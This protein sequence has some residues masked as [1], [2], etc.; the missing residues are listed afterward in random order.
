[1]TA[2]PSRPFPLLRLPLELREHVFAFYFNPFDRLVSHYDF[3]PP[4]PAISDGS[5]DR[6]EDT[7]GGGKYSFDFRL[8]RVNKQICGEARGVWKRVAGTFVMVDTPWPTAVHH[9]ST[10]G[11]V[12]IVASGPRASLFRDHTFHVEITAPRYDAHPDHSLVLL[13]E[14]VPLFAKTWY[15]SALSYPVLNTELHVSFKVRPVDGWLDCSYNDGEEKEVGIELQRKMVAPFEKVKG[16]R[17]T[18]FSG[19][20]EKVKEDVLKGMAIPHPSAQE[21]IESCA[22]L[23]AE[24]DTALASASKEPEKGQQAL[25][26]YRRAFH[27]IHVIIENRTRRVLAEGYFHET[28]PSGPFAGQ[29]GTTV[30]ILLR[31]RLVSRHVLA[32]LR[33]KKYGDAAFWGMRSIRI[34]R[35]AMSSEFEDLQTDFPGMSDVGPLCCRT[36]MAFQIMEDDEEVWKEE[37]KGYLEDEAGHS[38]ELWHLAKKYMRGLGREEERK[39]VRLEAKEFGVDIPAGVF[40]EWGKQVASEADSLGYLDLGEEEGGGSS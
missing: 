18:H 5:E 11:F 4:D 37:L 34:M 23:M 9:I 30:R 22:S 16:L 35:E 29:S 1:M 12:P 13:L 27:A 31:I 10:E 7:P 14:D 32:Y 15:Y 39:L 2:T 21:C 40:A 25:H 20:D 36:A 26:L 38:D 19:F 33:L 8:M 3:G 28:I 24:G 6:P 17:G